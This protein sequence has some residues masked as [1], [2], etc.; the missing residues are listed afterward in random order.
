MGFWQSSNSKTLLIKH[1]SFS[2]H[3]Q[4]SLLIL[5]TADLKYDNIALDDARIMVIISS[6]ATGFFKKNY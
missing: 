2:I 4:V 1:L 5:I 3:R 6:F